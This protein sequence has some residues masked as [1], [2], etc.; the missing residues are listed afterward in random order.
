MDNAEPV[1]VKVQAETSTDSLN[2]AFPESPTLTGVFNAYKQSTA[3]GKVDNILLN[4]D[5]TQAIQKSDELVEDVNNAEANIKVGADDTPA[6]T[7]V[8]GTL[9]D[10]ATKTTDIK[11]GANTNALVS[12]IQSKLSSRK[13]TINLKANVSGGSGG[14]SNETGGASATGNAQIGSSYASGTIG[15]K[16]TENALINELGNET[17]IDPAT[18]TYEIVE[19]GAQFR[20][21]KKGQIILNHLQTK[22]L[23]KFGKISSFGKMLFG[24]NAKIKGS[25][26]GGGTVSKVFGKL[27]GVAFA[28]GTAAGSLYSGGGKTTSDNTKATTDNTNA[29]KKNTKETN[30]STQ[31]FDWVARRLE[32][33]ADKTKAIADSIH[34][35]VTSLFK[36]SQLKAQIKAI[37]DEITANEKAANAYIKKADKVASKYT[38]YDDNGKKKSVSVSKKYQKLVQEGKWSIEDMDTSTDR[39]AAIA[40]AV[41]SY[42]DY[43]DKAKHC[44]QAIVDLRNEQLGLFEELA[45]IPTEKAEK[46]I[47]KLSTTLLELERDYAKIAGY[48]TKAMNTNLDKQVQN[49]KEQRDAYAEALADAQKLAN[50]TSTDLKN[51]QGSFTKKEL[52]KLSKSQRK[53]LNS[54]TEIDT[55]GLS[56]KTLE[57][58]NAYNQALGK[59]TIAL[60]AQQEATKNLI[61]ADQNYID[62]LHDSAKQKFDN[63]INEHEVVISDL[64][65]TNNITDAELEYRR[66]TGQSRV[67]DE[68]AKL[69]QDKTA[70]QGGIAI[71]MGAELLAAQKALEE[72]RADME[73]EAVA[74]AENKIKELEASI[75]EVKAS[76]ADLQDEYNQIELNKLAD[77][78]SVL[79]ANAE[80]LQSEMDLAEA[81]GYVVSDSQYEALIANSKEQQKNI[82]AQNALLLAQQEHYEKGSEKYNELQEQINANNQSLIDAEKSQAEWNDTIRDMPL[83]VFEKLNNLLSAVKSTYEN[84]LALRETQGEDR[85]IEEVRQ[86]LD[87]N[88]KLLE[89]E[90][91]NYNTHRDNFNETIKGN[92]EG[93]NTLKSLWEKMQTASANGNMEL[94]DSLDEQFEQLQAELGIPFNEALESLQKM[95]ESQ[96]EIYSILEENEK[97][98]DEVFDIRTKQLEDEKEELQKIKDLSDRA[99]K[100]EEARYALESAKE[101]KNLVYNGTEFV[102]QRDESEYKDALQNLQDAEYDELLQDID[103]GIERIADLITDYNLYDK[104]GN[105]LGDEDEIL[106]AA[107]AAADKIVEGLVGA[108]EKYNI[109]GVTG[110]SK[111]GVITSKDSNELD[112][113]AEALGED[114]MVAVKEGELV[115]PKDGIDLSKFTPITEIPWFKNARISEEMIKSSMIFDPQKMWSINS[116]NNL[117][118][119][120][121][122]QNQVTCTFNGGITVQGVQNADK[123]TDELILQLE[124]MMTQKLGRR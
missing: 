112:P 72:N 32:Y 115:V 25:A 86:L 33:F 17:I 50:S 71:A 122:K 39:K 100:L 90:R 47:D 10:I 48:D 107:I 19:G 3:I 31:V 40:E 102:Y 74:D 24:G 108:S 114:H 35:Y 118:K 83:T 63:I 49:A 124:P 116:Y 77:E 81:Q 53:A 34:D 92:T 105:P 7:K 104:Y 36:Q 15:A 78:M 6:K 110:Y 70:T 111:G 37:G 60:D 73:A 87:N 79:S 20:K 41:Q 55:T 56:G 76:V 68:Y 38:Y 117:P 65:A 4:A 98:L 59:N 26:Y 45:N 51:A 13:F 29:K 62:S 88:N 16:K 27:K 75:L 82:E 58:A 11:I 66:A 93:F 97:Y 8:N 121:V 123:F 99:L 80:M 106:Q 57:K 120:S 5:I 43:Y 67:S 9:S 96:G 61:D 28:G 21:I 85:T 44:Q 52:N 91:A 18:G 103:D 12:D 84:L 119:Q 109:N 30:H 54:G 42:Q 113:I 1:K 22:A 101:K 95:E 69:L 23:Q 89:N 46:K 14:K 64:E 2:S 94:S